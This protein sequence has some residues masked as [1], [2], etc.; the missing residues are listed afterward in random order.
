MKMEKKIFKGS[1]PDDRKAFDG[2]EF[3]LNQKIENGFLQITSE[4]LTFIKLALLKRKKK[5]LKKK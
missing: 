4:G 1:K 3:M 2:L 5:C